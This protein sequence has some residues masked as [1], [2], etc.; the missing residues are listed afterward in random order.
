MNLRNA[1]LCLIVAGSF[2]VLF[3]VNWATVSSGRAVADEPAADPALP[4][5]EFRRERA[6]SPEA[7]AA[8]LFRG[9]VLRSPERFVQHL[10]LGVCDGPIATLQKFAESLHTTEFRHGED[11]F[12]V[13]DL[14]RPIDP[15]KPIR[16]IASQEFDSD[17]DKVAALQF[18][19]LSSYYGERFVSVD[20]A[21]E[22]YDG[23]EYRTRIVVTQVGDGWYAIPRCRSSKSF[24]EIA[25]AM[26]LPSPG[27]KK[28][29]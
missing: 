3:A 14:P 12:T 22:G 13:Y 28:A 20:V 25:D 23:L 7:A 27:V 15:E 26:T 11:S 17:D 9:C 10:C 29:E 21:A 1:V 18:E 6:N 16:A 5:F 19:M 8:A 24:Y 2:C 4:S